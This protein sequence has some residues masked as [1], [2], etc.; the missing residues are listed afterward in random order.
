MSNLRH[1]A[2]E[3]KHFAFLHKLSC[4]VT[5]LRFPIE[6][7]H[8][9]YPDAAFHKE[10]TG[11]SRKPH[12]M[13]CLPLSAAEHRIQHS[14]GERRYWQERGFDPEDA[15]LSPLALC[16]D[17]WRFSETDDVDLAE[18]AISQHRWNVAMEQA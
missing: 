10:I 11:N 14:M 17:L 5:G 18:V 9:R 4:V 8:I 2:A 3:R 15:A 7:A 16:L 1:T 12:P 13:W 6:A